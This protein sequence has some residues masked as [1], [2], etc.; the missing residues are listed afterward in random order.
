MKKMSRILSMMLALAM[1]MVLAACGGGTTTSTAP[2]T[3]PSAAPAESA[4]PS[5]ERTTPKTPTVVRI[6]AGPVG[7][8]QNTFYN[9]TADHVNKDLPG[10]YNFMIEASTGSAENMRLLAAGEV[11]FGTSGL[12]QTKMA[13]EGTGSYEGL[14]TGNIRQV[15]VIAGTGAV[16]HVVTG[17]KSD[18]NTIED[19]AGKKVAATAGVMQGYL[20]DVLWAHDMSL[21]DLGDFTN[22]S[23][24]DMITALQDG[25][26][27][28]LCYG[29]TFPNVNFTD[30]AT[31]YGM[32][33]IDIG[34][35]YVAKLIAEKPWYHQ[36]IIPAGTYKGVDNDVYSFSQY[37]T[38]QA[39]KDVDDQVVYDILAT[40]Y[41]HAEDLQSL[42]P[43]YI[44]YGDVNELTRGNVVPYHPGAAKFYAEHGI[45][46]PTE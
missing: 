40:T 5:G 7:G 36:E 1:I 4:A 6:A 19:L 39:H 11:D 15:Y 38:L 2:S 30:L 12:D 44:K 16:V 24:A 22:L 23:L 42:H 46:V 25:T 21:D 27:D 10:F 3:E 43:N 29:N 35:E 41:A 33:L 9:T 18:I 31:T 8:T 34:E 28:A 13:N 17:P 26:I 37:S 14:P 32:K 45:T 20:E